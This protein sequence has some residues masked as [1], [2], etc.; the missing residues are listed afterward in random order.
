MLIYCAM[1]SIEEGEVS[2]TWL[3]RIVL[4]RNPAGNRYAEIL[5][6]LYVEMRLQRLRRLLFHYNPWERVRA[7]MLKN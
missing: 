5:F 6:L 2:P 3:T 1:G 4:S 7:S